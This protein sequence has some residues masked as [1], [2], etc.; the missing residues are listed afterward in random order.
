MNDSS[1]ARE[2]PPRKFLVVE[3]STPKFLLFLFLICLR[4]IAGPEPTS[5]THESARY[6]ALHDFATV[7]SLGFLLVY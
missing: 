3:K 2:L 6:E 1:I 7:R 4:S 5:G